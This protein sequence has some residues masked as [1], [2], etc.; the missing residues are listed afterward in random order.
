MYA[1]ARVIM[2]LIDADAGDKGDQAA[3]YW[4]GLGDLGPQPVDQRLVGLKFSDH[5]RK[6]DELTL[7]F[8]NSDYALFDTSAF[9]RGQKYLVSFGWPGRMSV[10]RRFVVV[11]VDGGD[12]LV[13]KLHDTTVLMDRKKQHRFAANA[14]DS[15]F[16]RQI[17]EEHGYKGPTAHVQDTVIRRDV[18]QPQWRT[19]AR[20]MA[21]L[22]Q[23]NGFLFYV[24]GTGLHW[25]ER[26]W[27]DKPVR[28]F[29]Y[30]GDP[31]QGT[32]IDQPQVEANL[33]KGVTT[34]RVLA[35]DPRTKE[36]IDIT[37][38]PQDADFVSL[39]VERE[40]GAPGGGTGKRAD[41][42]TRED[43]RV[44]G[45]MTREQAQAEAEARFRSTAQGKYKMSFTILGDATLTAKSIVEVVGVADVLDGLWWVQEAEHEIGGNRIYTTKLQLR[46]DTLREVKARKKAERQSK[47]NANKGPDDARAKRVA[48][49][50]NQNNNVLRKSATLRF[51]PN[52]QPVVAWFYVDQGE[53]VG[54]QLSAR[55]LRELDAKAKRTIAS[56]A[57]AA[58]LPDA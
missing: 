6:K 45:Y 15:E 8:A 10:P 9:T 56:Q 35:R 47:V 2:Q 29:I 33:T 23:R 18:T 55:E 49:Y 19:D 38:G 51:G 13:V 28:T 14:T 46:K 58:E 48:A 4:V 20:Q 53:L 1:G 31:N 40:D 34:V 3:E 17:A 50:I 16:V 12:P 42:V 24:D 27:Q 41:R 5:E 21:W 30:R 22:A 11:K 37:V 36:N 25:H 43:V 32:I 54:G 57:A 52:G 44:L 7:A 26:A 39:G